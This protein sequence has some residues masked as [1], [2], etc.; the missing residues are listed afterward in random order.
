MLRKTLAIAAAVVIAASGSPAFADDFQHWESVNVTVNLPDSF[1]VSSE[2]VLRTSDARGF[3]EVEQS[4]MLGKKLNK[5]VTV[6]LGYTFDPLY[7]HGTFIRREHRFRQQVNFDGFATLGKVKF[8]GRL[9][10]EERW[11]E[12]IP[13]TAW[14]LRPQVK[15]AVPFVGKSTLTF[16]TEEFID[17]NNTAFQPVDDFERMR[18][19]VT[20]TV[21]LSKKVNLD[22]G[23][24]YQ[25]GF[26][27]AGIDTHDHVLT[28]GITATF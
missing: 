14:R 24:L 10:L 13:G 18:N 9:R 25:H 20:I 15:A 22:F 12:G 8:S 6:W 21:P 19:S 3:Y 1:K 27:R 4:L 16:A 23:Y 11:R 28:T 26:V 7:S 5:K 2:T 17:L